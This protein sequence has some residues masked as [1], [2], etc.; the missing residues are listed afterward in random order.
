MEE[1]KEE[2]LEEIAGAA[3]RFLYDSKERQVATAEL[4]SGCCQG[5]MSGR[6]YN[7]K[8]QMANGKWLMFRQTVFIGFSNGRICEET[9]L[10]VL[11]SSITCH[12]AYKIGSYLSLNIVIFCWFQNKHISL[13]LL[14]VPSSCLH[15]FEP[16][17]NLNFETRI[18][19]FPTF[20]LQPRPCSIPSS[21]P[22]QGQRTLF[23][24]V[25]VPVS[26]FPIGKDN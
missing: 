17:K 5:R 22:R 7:D 20:C 19:H 25:M 13:V 4:Q 15:P 26:F 23:F 21:T 18:I 3:I 16:I 11:F 12:T 1:W 8:G 6:E 9:A 24:Y 14:F 10:N 2:R